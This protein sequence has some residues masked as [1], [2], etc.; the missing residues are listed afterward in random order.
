M[1]KKVLIA[2][3]NDISTA[4]AQRLFHCGFAVTMISQSIPTDLYYFR[5]YSTVIV[6]GAK[7]IANIKAQSY[8]DFLYNIEGNNKTLDEFVEFSSNNRQIAVLDPDDIKKISVTFDYMVIGDESLF[9][10]LDIDTSNL[11]FI[12]CVS[13]TFDFSK[14]NIILNGPNRGQVKYPFLDFE[15]FEIEK[16]ENIV[17]ADLEAVFVAEKFPGDKVNKDEKIAMLG[18]DVVK[19]NV[20]GFIEGIMRSGVIVAKGQALVHIS[21]WPNKYIKELPMASVSV[22]GGVLEAIMYDV[23]LNE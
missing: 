18:E 19:A 10:L 4:C 1:H 16:K 14:Y 5:N 20:N 12:S 17:N 9:E 11:T 8:S 6:S 13:K 23:N 21:A 7:M 22:S 3:T 15:V 2:G